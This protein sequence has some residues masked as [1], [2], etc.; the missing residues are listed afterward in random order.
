MGL[1]RGN[2]KR[3][4]AFETLVTEAEADCR[5]ARTRA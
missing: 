1:F 4:G 2:V 3:E 5:A